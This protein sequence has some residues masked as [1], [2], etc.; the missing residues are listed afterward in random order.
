MA[1]AKGARKQ[2]GKIQIVGNTKRAKKL[3][4]KKTGDALVDRYLVGADSKRLHKKYTLNQKYSRLGIR[5]NVNAKEGVHLKDLRRLG[6]SD[7]AELP[8]PKPAKIRHNIKMKDPVHYAWL[9]S[10]IEKHQ[11][12]YKMMARDPRNLFQLTPKQLRKQV[13]DYIR[14]D[15]LARP[16]KY[17]QYGPDADP[18]QIAGRT[19]DDDEW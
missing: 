5:H 1:H 17:A 14:I 3:R 10:L 2:R 19:A 11:Y 9:E 15:I 4:T 16:E 7:L 6:E 18:D 13:A 12:N 8:A